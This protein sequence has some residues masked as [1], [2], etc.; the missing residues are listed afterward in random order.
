MCLRGAPSMQDNSTA[1]VVNADK[2]DDMDDA[3][4]VVLLR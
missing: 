3:K 2:D 1:K 4:D